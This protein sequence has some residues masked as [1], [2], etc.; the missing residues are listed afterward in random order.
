MGA[1]VNHRVQN[2]SLSSWTPR[3]LIA[4][5]VSFSLDS[6]K[7]SNNHSFHFTITLQIRYCIT[8]LG[9]VI[10]EF[11]RTSANSHLR[12]GPTYLIHR[13]QAN[14]VVIPRKN[15]YLLSYKVIMAQT[16][17]RHLIHSA[18]YAYLKCTKPINLRFACPN[19]QFTQTKLSKFVF[20]L[21]PPSHT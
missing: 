11:R 21:L 1:H 9:F 15:F 19:F 5:L 3:Q 6:Y 4:I 16:V 20:S 13:K 2:C 14:L 10:L 8:R 7:Y 18:Y 12:E 17:Y